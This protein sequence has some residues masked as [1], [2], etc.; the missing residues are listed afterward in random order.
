[1]I[2][3]H[4]LGIVDRLETVFLRPVPTKADPV[5]TPTN[6]LSKIPALILDDG[7]ALYDSA[8][9]CEYLMTLS[10]RATLVPASGLER[11]RVLRQQALCD[12]I[13]EAGILVFYEHASRP[14]ELWWPAWLE[15]QTEKATLALDALEREVTTFGPN[16]DLGQIC[17]GVALGWLEFRNAIGDVRS[18]RPKLFAWYD[19]FAKRPSMLA[20]VPRL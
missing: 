16:V 12:G 11:F 2:V 4:E 1:M 19:E 9:I 6:P 18:S 7:T 15:G 5:L 14:K 10:E 8:V 20:T 3:A 17:V 13:L